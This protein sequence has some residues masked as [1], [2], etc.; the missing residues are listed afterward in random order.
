[1]S[2]PLPGEG[3]HPPGDQLPGEGDQVPGDQ[4]PGEEPLYAAVDACAEDSDGTLEC[5]REPLSTMSSC[6]SLDQCASMLLTHR[7]HQLKHSPS[8]DGK[9]I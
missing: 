1:M 5:I 3:D 2:C 7:P 4:V 6:Q 9:Q 8:R